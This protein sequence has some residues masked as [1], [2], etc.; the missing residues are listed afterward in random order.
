VPAAALANA[1]A[2]TC[3]WCEASLDGAA[4]RDRLAICPACG[5]ATTD[6]I[7]TAAELDDAYASWY[8][9]PG[10]RFS[11]PGDMVLQRLRARYAR[12]IDQ[13]APAGPILDVGSGDGTLLRALRAEGREAVGLER[14]GLGEGVL[15]LELSELGGPYAGIVFWHT[16]EHL[17]NAGASAA[18]A[19]ELLEPGGALAIAVPNFASFQA[20]LFGDRWLALDLPR[21]L[22]H[23]PAP[24]LIERLRS[25]GLEIER[26]S[27]AR[28]G[29]IV[30]GWL[31]GLVGA[32][33]PGTDLYDALRT[34]E[35]RRAQ[36][37]PGRRFAALALG[38]AMLPIATAAAVAEV[39]ARRGGTVYVEGRRPRLRPS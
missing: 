35:A 27:Y 15:D 14:E 38:A 1:R 18:R 23:I 9:P 24:A 21:H 11:G 26:V 13:I 22:V 5:A 31:H 6:P 37:S 16:L 34:P 28:G 10:G 4:R 12:R 32:V 25:L 29:Q 7:P 39:C 30:F 8:R 17:P 3:A 20:R 33:M 19:V 36:I 2:T